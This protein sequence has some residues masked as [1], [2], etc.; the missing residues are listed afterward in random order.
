MA[1]QALKYPK[2]EAER[3]TQT[4][5]CYMRKGVAERR[6]EHL[7]KSIGTGGTEDTCPQAFAINKEVPPSS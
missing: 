3:L 6:S 7:H 1:A 5:Y 2:E 4:H